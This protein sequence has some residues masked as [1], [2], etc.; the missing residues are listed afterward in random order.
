MSVSCPVGPSQ[1]VYTITAHVMQS[2]CAPLPSPKVVPRCF[3]SGVESS[4]VI[5]RTCCV[6][7]LLP[8]ALVKGHRLAWPGRSPGREKQYARRALDAPHS[9]RKIF[10]AE[11]NAYDCTVSLSMNQSSFRFVVKCNPL[12]QEA[13]SNA[14]RM[15]RAGSGSVAAESAKVELC[16]L[17]DHC[18]GW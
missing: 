17:S 2:K 4:V 6:D 1:Q 3:R 7:C 18:G 14:T 10:A 5:L 15:R 8:L 12:Q 9:S 11:T 13:W 16:R